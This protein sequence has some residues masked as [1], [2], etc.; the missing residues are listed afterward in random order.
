MCAG[1]AT[2]EQAGNQGS[3]GAA[4]AIGL[5]V[6]VAVAVPAAG[7]IGTVL[8]YKWRKAANRRRAHAHEFQQKSAE[9][10]GPDIDDSLVI[11]EAPGVPRLLQFHH[12]V[13]QAWLSCRRNLLVGIVIAVCVS[14]LH[15]KACT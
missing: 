8:Y 1:K 7:A 13:N 4:P 5:I 15:L 10:G 12:E 14:S 9:E 6:A 11:V 2:A 3:S